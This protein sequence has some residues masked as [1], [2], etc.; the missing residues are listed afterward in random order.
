MPNFQNKMY[1]K[2]D[3]VAKQQSMELLDEDQKDV[4]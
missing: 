2:Q 3:I 1:D 4:T